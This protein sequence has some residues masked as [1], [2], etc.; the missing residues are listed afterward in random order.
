MP[1]ADLCSRGRRAPPSPPGSPRGTLAQSAGAQG[2]SPAVIKPG[3]AL[4]RAEWRLIEEDGGGIEARG[5][6]GGW[7][8][9]HA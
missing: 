4:T 9:V 2:V 8:S 3:R 7:A 6:G 5:R 1:S